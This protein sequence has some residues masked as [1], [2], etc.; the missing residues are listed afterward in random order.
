MTSPR[1]QVISCVMKG[2]P[3]TVASMLSTGTIPAG[4]LDSINFNFVHRFILSTF[5]CARCYCIFN[6]QIL[7]IATRE[8][9]L[10][11]RGIVRRQFAPLR[12]TTWHNNGSRTR[13]RARF[14]YQVRLLHD[15]VIKWEHFPRYWPFVR[16]IHRSRWIPHTKASD[17][18]LWC[19]LWSASE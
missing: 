12:S 2:G 10:F 9:Y 8:P 15:D 1:H 3:D 13:S 6:T 11:T 14:E 18:E 17:A 7:V 19:F 5:D 16:G 4:R